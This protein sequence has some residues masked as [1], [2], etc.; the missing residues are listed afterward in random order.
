MV[1][2][3]ADTPVLLLAHSDP[4]VRHQLAKDIERSA[5]NLEVVPVASKY[6][7]YATIG[8]IA[9]H[10]GYLAAAI[11]D[12]T[13]V[14]DTG[15]NLLRGLHERYPTAASAILAPPHSGHDP[16]VY[17][18]SG[19]P[20]RLRTDVNKLQS[21]SRPPHPRVAVIGPEGSQLAD[22]ILAILHRTLTPSKRVIRNEEHITVKID[23][24]NEELID[25][26]PGEIFKALRLV[27]D[28]KRPLDHPYDLIIVGAGPAGLSA[29]LNAS[30]NVGLSTLIIENQIPG[31]I[32][33][34]SI[35][36]IDNYLGFPQGVSGP[37]LAQLA[38]EQVANLDLVDFLPTLEAQ[39]IKKAAHGRYLVEALD[40]MRGEKIDLNAGMILLACGS[41]PHELKLA[42]GKEHYPDRGVYYSALPCDQEREK[43]KIVVIIGGG[44]SAGQAALQFA[45]KSRKVVMV[46]QDGF[47]RM[48]QALQNSIR[49]N[50]KIDT[51]GYFG[52]KVVEF[53]GARQ[54]EA[55]KVRKANGSRS[56]KTR[57]IRAASAYVLIGGDPDTAWVGKKAAPHCER[58]AQT[59]KKYIKTDVYLKPH[60]TKL[61]FE[62]SLDGVFAAG[63]V[64]VNSLRRV[65]QAVGQGAAAV[66]SMERYASNNP[67]IL[68]DRDSPAYTRFNVLG[69]T[70]P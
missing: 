29:A 66:A 12:E 51:E 31:G 57:E 32:A 17:V 43:D 56:L 52:Y 37:A 10:G 45:K 70:K 30:V 36:P 6:D 13:L 68:V 9:E 5:S 3:P 59:Q 62:T 16:S 11:A 1:S 44:D 64:R 14:D 15:E 34:T 41:R 24:T 33:T 47:D 26:H 65:G 58:V 39:G 69:L 55:I 49:E 53:M 28:P 40:Q 67:R 61:P 20:E 63:D 46:A 8:A 23:G 19:K 7:A 42:K 50:S 48:S 35:N 2:V 38:L 25:P 54:L 60:G 21:K 4:W 27:R 18:M 22:E